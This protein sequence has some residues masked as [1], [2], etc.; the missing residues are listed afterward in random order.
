M[1]GWGNDKKDKDRNPPPLYVFEICTSNH[2]HVKKNYF[3]DGK[4]SFC[5][6]ISSSSDEAGVAYG[7]S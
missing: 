5:F 3:H 1:E 6:F 4:L 7:F 2:R